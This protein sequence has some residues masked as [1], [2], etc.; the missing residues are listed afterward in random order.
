MKIEMKPPFSHSPLHLVL[1]NQYM[2]K[3][4]RSSSVK[5]PR[6][7]KWARLLRA[8]FKNR[9]DRE[10]QQL[11][12]ISSLPDDILHIIL[13]KLPIRDAA[14]TSAVSKRWAPLFS[15]LP[16]LNIHAAS[17][18]PVNPE[19]DSDDDESNV[20]DVK[21]WVGA[22]FSVLDSRRAPFQKFEIDVEIL[23]SCGGDFYKVFDDL[24][25]AG[26]QELVIRNYEYWNDI[27][28]IPWPVYFCDT[29]VKLE[30]V[31]CV[32]D[33]PLKFTGLRA[34]KS[35]ELI[36]VTV[37]DN[38]LRRMISRCKA[39][40][41]LVI[42]DFNKV[43]NI[44]IRAP[45]LLEL[46]I[47]SFRPLAISLKSS[48]RLSNVK[49][50]FGY[51][52]KDKYS[53]DEYSDGDFRLNDSEKTFEG[54]NL[55]AFLN[56]LHGVKNLR[57]NFSNVYRMMLSKEGVALPTM[58]SPKCYLLELKKLCLSWLYNYH[59]FNMILSCLLN[60]SPHL[61]EIIICVDTS[62]DHK[63]CPTALE[64]DFWDKQSPAECVKN[65]LI[66]ATFYLG[67]YK[68]EDCFG[69]PK[70]L[71]LNAEILKNMNIFY[72]LRKLQE[73]SET[74]KI[75]NELLTMQMAS[76]DVEITIK[77]IISRYRY[78]PNF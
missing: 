20:E 55:M 13:S 53:E 4:L 21:G 24:C 43:K 30:I 74:T 48:P 35:L 32:L 76:P 5:L 64:L 73:E 39:I 37:A 58:L 26:V 47:S 10:Q 38:H 66:I 18:N 27:Y 46:V 9:K 22:L 8:Y 69:F 31:N 77:P 59:T 65:H 57:L 23:D 17:F 56:G 71:L 41:K 62:N 2:E 33:V 54:T 45:S 3:N 70:F 16:S 60:S 29:I 75:K 14:V 25:A 67:S 40:E 7:L 63:Y 44:V 6:L 19:I 50:S 42:T 61:S 34:V 1:Q 52:V 36:D 51:Y 72:I 78:I 68:S 12:L 11:D 15:T 28:E 49:V